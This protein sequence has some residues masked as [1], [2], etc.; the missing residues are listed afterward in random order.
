MKALDIVTAVLLVIGGLNWGLVGF[1]NF[2]LISAVFGEATA[3]SKLFYALFGLSALYETFTFAFGYRAMQDRW[4]E[5]P[6]AVK[7]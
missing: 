5:H 6:A 4:C 3:F 1:F 7:H 2:D